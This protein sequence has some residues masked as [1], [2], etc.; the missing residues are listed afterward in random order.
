[1]NL[2]FCRSPVS[3]RNMDQICVKLRSVLLLW[4]TELRS[5]RIWAKIAT[6]RRIWQGIL[7][8]LADL[9]KI[10][11]GSADLRT[12]IHPH[13]PPPW[14][15]SLGA[16]LLINLNQNFILL[17]IASWYRGI[18]PS[19]TLQVIFTAIFGCANLTSCKTRLIMNDHIV[20]SFKS[21]TC[22]QLIKT[23]STV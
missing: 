23:L 6:D 20:A 13:P 5:I 11:H 18:R 12:P 2:F 7:H 8:G 14:H 10:W 9:H 1:M 3:I 16:D 22:V 19:S 17:K 21:R 4:F 15:A